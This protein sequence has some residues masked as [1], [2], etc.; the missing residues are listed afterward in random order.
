MKEAAPLRDV[1]TL[2]LYR[3]TSCSQGERCKAVHC[4]HHHPGQ[5][6]RRTPFAGSL[7]PALP[8]GAV[9]P[10]ELL[11]AW[12]GK[13]TPLVPAYADVLAPVLCGSAGCLNATERDY[14]PQN[15]KRDA[16]QLS[17]C[18]SPY[19]HRAHSQT[20]KSAFDEVREALN[21]ASDPL[22]L[23]E[24]LV[25]QT[26]NTIASINVPSSSSLRTAPKEKAEP[27]PAKFVLNEQLETFEHLHLEFK[28]FTR[29]EVHTA[30]DYICGFLN[31][32]GGTLL[33]GV[34]DDGVVRG[35]QLT[36]RDIDSFQINLDISLRSFIPSV[37]PDQVT[38]SFY[39]LIQP[40]N[41]Q[42][43]ASQRYVVEIVVM[44]SPPGFF[45]VTDRQ[46]FFIKKHG[47]LNKL[48]LS[49]VV[50]L[51]RLRTLQLSPFDTRVI[52][53]MTAEQRQSYAAA[54]QRQ[55]TAV[56]SFR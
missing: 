4:L 54:L 1:R 11:R 46:E 2:L 23:L 47:S 12:L 36:R 43:D 51:V 31:S 7:T 6:P 56:K 26:N 52:E 3:T 44:P 39:P 25:S 42:S 20:E 29:L 53:S 32:F 35:V 40:Q 8:V 30:L 19:C 55:L 28:Q 16:C 13:Q 38:L 48:S 18:T 34:N 49:E 5:E 50:G 37:I 33:F 17:S 9:S 45:Y 22:S 15:F 24:A 27:K 21:P 41:G 14:H 10:L